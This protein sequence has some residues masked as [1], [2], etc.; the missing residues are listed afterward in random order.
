MIKKL[1]G[2]LVAVAVIAVIVVLI[3]LYFVLKLFLGR[4]KTV[5]NITS[6]KSAPQKRKKSTR[7]R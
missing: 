3:L 1:I 6:E 2:I 4:N 7:R 5:V